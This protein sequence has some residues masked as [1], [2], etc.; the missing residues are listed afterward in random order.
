[1]NTFM[2]EATDLAHSGL[3]DADIVVEAGHRWN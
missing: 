2:A 3:V 1:M